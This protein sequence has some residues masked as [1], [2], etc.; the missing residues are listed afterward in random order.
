MQFKYKDAVI[1]VNE[2]V[3]VME[4]SEYKYTLRETK[5]ETGL[6]ITDLE[7]FMEY[8]ELVY[9]QYFSED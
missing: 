6:P 5:Y 7:E 2:D 4:N 9:K 8:I 1:T 3:M